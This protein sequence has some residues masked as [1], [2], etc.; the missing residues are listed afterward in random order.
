[1]V[2]AYLHS[3]PNKVT[4][5]K[6]MA[7]C[8]VLEK[9]FA[10]VK[11]RPL[12]SL[13]DPDS[14]AAPSLQQVAAE[15]MEK[16]LSG[17][18]PSALEWNSMA[19]E[20]VRSLFASEEFSPA[21]ACVWSREMMQAGDDWSTMCM[22]LVQALAHLRDTKLEALAHIFQVIAM[23]AVNVLAEEGTAG[24]QERLLAFLVVSMGELLVFFDDI[25]LFF[26]D[27][28]RSTTTSPKVKETAISLLKGLL[29]GSHPL[30]QAISC[31]VLQSLE[32]RRRRVRPSVL[33]TALLALIEYDKKQEAD[34]IAECVI[35]GTGE[36]ACIISDEVCASILL[37]ASDETRERLNSAALAPAE[38]R[39]L[40]ACAM[41][42]VSISVGRDPMPVR[43]SACQEGDRDNISAAFRVLLPHIRAWGI[44]PCL[45]FA[46]LLNDECKHANGAKGAVGALQR[47]PPSSSPYGLGSSPALSASASSAEHV[48][49]RLLL[50]EM[51][52]ILPLHS[53]LA[54]HFN[55][56]LR[57][58]M[59]H[60]GVKEH[61][62]KR[63]SSV[64]S[65]PE[66]LSGNMLMCE[67][68]AQ[69]Q[70][71]DDD[72]M[73]TETQSRARDR[74]LCA[75]RDIKL[76]EDLIAL[77]IPLLSTNDVRLREAFFFGIL[78]Q[79]EKIIALCCV[80]TPAAA[81]PHPHMHASTT[82]PAGASDGRAH[83]FM[84]AQQNVLLR[85]RLLAAAHNKEK[86]RDYLAK[87]GPVLLRLLRADC[88]Q[89]SETGDDLTSCILYTID[90]LF[91]DKS[92]RD[93]K[94]SS[95]D[96]LKRLMC[97]ELQRQSFPSELHWRI[98]RCSWLF[99]QLAHPQNMRLVQTS[100]ITP[101]QVADAL[102]RT[103][104]ADNASSTGAPPQS[105]GAFSGPGSAYFH[106][107]GLTPSPSPVRSTPIARTPSPG[108]A[109]ATTP[110]GG[111]ASTTSSGAG[112]AGASGANNTTAAFT[113]RKASVE[114]VDPWH[115]LEDFP[116]APPD[117]RM[118]AGVRR[119]RRQLK[120]ASAILAGSS[121]H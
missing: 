11:P 94:K 2:N 19:S 103:Q 24:K 49:P 68:M 21:V 90:L 22:V 89:T 88:M 33:V 27:V 75:R 74:R 97:D 8:D 12:P 112:T 118:F 73:D 80:T 23:A 115:M 54:H 17:H 64:L 62:F 28:L 42:T 20:Q 40:F 98:V 32:D 85:L 30:H 77:L 87:I 65:A 61:L 69:M 63:I 81:P 52:A 105:T 116:P 76:Q 111:F 4:K 82:A 113:A 117:A 110:G 35:S 60:H 44:R 119:E 14:A 109:S 101:A 3:L 34:T 6:I 83:S 15:L 56:L 7:D 25:P 1:M 67:Y 93:D 114:E 50:D 31:A 99:E 53:S 16:K 91:D 70:V 29:L 45:V 92:S 108:G 47:H 10:S 107:M 13:P 102:Y 59:T 86:P 96:D 55:A 48:V 57:H 104:N 79:L 26:A 18:P 37:G 46:R 39:V 9:T 72:T 120:Y 66:V 100:A 36:H 121:K 51:F 84:R 78:D 41:N 58:W 43:F 5:T 71:K 38:R 106:G 95:R